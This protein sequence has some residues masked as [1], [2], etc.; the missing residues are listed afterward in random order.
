MKNPLSRVSAE[1]ASYLFPVLVRKIQTLGRDVKD[2]KETVDDLVDE[3]QEVKEE[4]KM[5][6][7][8]NKS[9]LIL[10]AT[11]ISILS[12][13]LFATPYLPIVRDAL[14][15]NNTEEGVK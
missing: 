6:E 14:H 8:Q 7:K 10:W 9:I 1:E 3:N 15:N 12:V 5:T 11:I 13:G 2:L 4:V